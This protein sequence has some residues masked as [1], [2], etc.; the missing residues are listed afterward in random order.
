MSEILVDLA[1]DPVVGVRI[2]LAG[3][4]KRWRQL[5]LE[6]SSWQQ[7]LELLANDEECVSSELL[8]D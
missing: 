3:S 2:A 6:D 7:V 5:K 8:S 4:L 1:K